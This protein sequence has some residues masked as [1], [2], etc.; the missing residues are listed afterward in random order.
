[1]R[2]DHVGFLGYN[3]PTTPFLDSLASQ[4]LVFTNAIA[5]GSPTYYSVPAILASRHSL[6]L[7]RDLLGLAPDETTITS[8]LKE[9]GFRT[10][11]FLAA[12]PYLSSRFGY[13]QA[14]DT[15]LDFLNEGVEIHSPSGG[16]G[17]TEDSLRTRANRSLARTC[18]NLPGAGPIYDE[19]YFRYCQKFG[20]SEKQSFDNL[21]RFPAADVIVDH[22]ISWL[23]QNS[24][25]PFFLW[26]HLMDPHSPYFPKQR[27]LAEM[28]HE[29]TA[30]EARYLNS[31]WAR[32][33]VSARRLEKKRDRVIALYDAGI[34]WA[35]NQIRRLSEKLVDLNLW[36]QCALAV[37]ADH[38]EQFL[39]HGQRFHPPLKL[40]QELIRVPLLLRGANH[41]GRKLDSPFSLI[42]L[43]PTLLDILNIP[44]PVGF[45]GQSCFEH[46]AIKSL[47]NNQAEDQMWDRAVVSEC[48]RGCTNPFYATNRE[49]PRIL[50]V[51]VR[52]FKL[53][54]DFGTMSEELFDLSSD[55][56]E[57]RAL[58]EDA[59]PLVR[60]RLLESAKQH[61]A[62][63]RRPENVESRLYSQLRNL[64]QEWME[65]L[66]S[67]PN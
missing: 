33:D 2:A 35:D 11:A 30:A 13:E 10:A 3:R 53:V 65:P 61:L 52:N 38:G 1:M 36:D 26:L 9:S 15:F 14:F 31:Y 37:T 12:N 63:S 27:V 5:A 32:G 28:G 50:A 7:G 22:A 66:A 46:S 24:S 59:E 60:R 67:R 19:L 34:R 54:I 17:R 47:A 40:N 64:S 55:P 21:R 62:E 39:E 51:R 25:R 8:M 42:D 29:I 16:E 45:R 41:A 56:A 18:H 20:A 44:I 58:P 49:G 57:S 48:V 23:N 43:A 6:A 4:S